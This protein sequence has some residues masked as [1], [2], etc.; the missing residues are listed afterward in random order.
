MKLRAEKDIERAK[1]EAKDE[2]KKEMI[3][4]ALDASSVILKRE[5]NSDDNARLVEEFIKDIE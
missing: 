1:E 3:N 4:I 2:I 5:V